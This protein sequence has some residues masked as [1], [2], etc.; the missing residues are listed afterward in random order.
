M[1]RQ[2][3]GPPASNH[4]KNLLSTGGATRVTCSYCAREHVAIDSCNM[5]D[6]YS[7][8]FCETTD[9]IRQWAKDQPDTYILHEDVDFVN[10]YSLRGM[11][12]VV[13]CPCNG[14]R[15]YEDFMWEEREM[16]MKYLALRKLS[17]QADLDSLQ[18]I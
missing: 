2:A 7:T 18:G 11:D 9:T 15:P 1:H 5:I 8:H 14:L 12:F 3:K 4:F 6:G 13:D 17:L 10:Y 16:W